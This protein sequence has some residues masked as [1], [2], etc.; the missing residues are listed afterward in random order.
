MGL[1]VRSGEPWVC[2]SGQESR[3]SG[4]E[5]RGSAGSARKAVGGGPEAPD[6]SAEDPQVTARRSSTTAGWWCRSRYGYGVLVMMPSGWYGG[7]MVSGWLSVS[8]NCS[9]I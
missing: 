7:L 3:W 5:S 8:S 1:R 9:E 4:Q 6:R 2:G